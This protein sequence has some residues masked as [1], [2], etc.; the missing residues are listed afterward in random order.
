MKNTYF[1]GAANSMFPLPLRDFTDN[2]LAGL[3]QEQTVPL[4]TLST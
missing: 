3:D 2:A 1:L 4:S